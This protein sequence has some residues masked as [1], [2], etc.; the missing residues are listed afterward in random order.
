MFKLC[1]IP[2]P[3]LQFATQG[4]GR[5]Q[6]SR[7]AF[8]QKLIYLPFGAMKG[9]PPEACSGQATRQNTHKPTIVD[10]GNPVRGLL[11]AIELPM[12]LNL[13]VTAVDCRNHQ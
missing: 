2:H 8:T 10:F 13:F 3:C 7:R 5:Q 12:G 9:T 6:C 11:W 1:Y 4:D